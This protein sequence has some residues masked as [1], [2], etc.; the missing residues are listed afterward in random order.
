MGPG[1]LSSL[2]VGVWRKAP[3]TFRDSNTTL[4][5]DQ[6]AIEPSLGGGG[7]SEGGL[8]REECFGD[9]LMPENPMRESRART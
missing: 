4:E 8:S 2:G 6:S 1:I 5:T 9:H 7:F 3:E